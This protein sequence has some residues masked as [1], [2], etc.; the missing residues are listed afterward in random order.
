MG[1]SVR[2]SFFLVGFVLIKSTAQGM[3]LGRRMELQEEEVRKENVRSAQVTLQEATDALVQY[4]LL[5]CQKAEQDFENQHKVNIA[6]SPTLRA[7]KLPFSINDSEEASDSQQ[8]YP[9]AG[10]QER[11]YLGKGFFS[12]MRKL[13]KR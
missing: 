13:F 11:E 3:D 7:H 6:T 9:D 1:I 8:E 5:K 10:E 12:F 2:K 4:Y